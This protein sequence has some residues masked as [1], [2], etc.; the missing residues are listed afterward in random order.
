MAHVELVDQTLRDGPQSLWG[1]RI[2]AGMITDAAPHLERAGFQ[3]IDVPAGSFFS[4]ILRYLREDPIEY[5]RHLR[6]VLPTSRLR[7]GTRPSSTGRYG[8]SPHALLDFYIRF[9]VERLGH[10][11]FWIYDCLFDMREMEYRSRVIHD[12]GGEPVPA[13]MYGISPVHT[14]AWFAERV[15]TM[16]S[17]GI[18]SAIYVEDAAGIL[19]PE[20]ARTL[21][22]A[23]VEAAGDVPVEL[24]C[25]N[26]TGLAPINYLIG[27]EAGVRR[28]HTC[29]RPV[30][31][32]PSLPSTEM[33]LV[34]LERAGHTHD[35]DTSALA[36]LADH[37]ERI[38]RQEGHPIGEVAEYDG[39]IYDH[40]LPGG[41]TGT[42]KA[43]LAQHGME[44]RLRD[45]L[46]EIPQVRE[47]LGHPISATPFSQLVGTQAVLNVITGERYAQTTDEVALYVM[48]AYGDPPAPIDPDVLDRI[49]SNPRGRALAGWRRPERTLDEVRDELG[50]RHLSDEELF[51][52][53]FAPPEDIELMRAAGPL[54]T[55]YAFRDGLDAAITEAL[56]RR[57]ARRVQLRTGSYA[58]DLRR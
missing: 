58:L 44:D 42:F 28:L 15:R 52:R 13:V 20:R 2:R 18:A 56:E 45:V 37:M 47:E 40:Q 57:S 17:W 4:V 25:H 9:M 10:D 16:V 49:L 43:Q 30:A 8:I 12:C 24:H 48:G 27:V 54:Q 22:P 34:N 7:C 36:P 6:R 11:A 1:M 21:L 5:Y 50:G 33:T 14:D 35:I 46:N 29:S 53:N 38:A 23:L 41:M 31:N 51:R 3:T 39:R 19:T 32:G 55:Q 26:T